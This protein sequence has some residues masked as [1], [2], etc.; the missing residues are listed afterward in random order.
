MNDRDSSVAVSTDLPSVIC[1]IIS[2]YDSSWN[3]RTEYIEINCYGNDCDSDVREGVDGIHCSYCTGSHLCDIPNEDRLPIDPTQL[4]DSMKHLPD[5]IINCDG[6]KCRYDFS[7][8]QT[9]LWCH[10]C[11]GKYT[12]SDYYFEW[13]R[14]QIKYGR[15][16]QEIVIDINNI[17]G[18][19]DE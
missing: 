14:L 15:S 6:S 1:Q 7:Y 12:R 13:T 11:H 9:G 18:I 16:T 8:D 3:A 4:F 5:H 2:E 19:D 17:E 10:G